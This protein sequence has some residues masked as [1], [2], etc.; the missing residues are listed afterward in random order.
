[1]L[2]LNVGDEDV[3]LLAFVGRQR[4]LHV[5]VLEICSVSYLDEGQAWDKRMVIATRG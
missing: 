1:M 2:I 4:R 5:L 3:R